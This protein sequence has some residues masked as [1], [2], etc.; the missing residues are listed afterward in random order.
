MPGATV[1]GSGGYEKSFVAS[2]KVNFRERVDDC[3]TYIDIE[4]Y[5]LSSALHLVIELAE[6]YGVG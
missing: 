2:E 3:H 1:A 6:I 5:T 4:P